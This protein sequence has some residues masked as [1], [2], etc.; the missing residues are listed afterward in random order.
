MNER[1]DE[2]LK[3]W[4]CGKCKSYCPMGEESARECCTVPE[5][6]GQHN[7]ANKTVYKPVTKRP[8]VW[9]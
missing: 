4:Q 1:Y 9:V 3:A 5:E 7:K 6:P 8:G 2:R